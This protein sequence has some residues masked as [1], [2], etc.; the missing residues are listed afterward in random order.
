MFNM[1]VDF[2]F[3]N[4]GVMDAPRPELMHLNEQIAHHIEQYIIEHQLEPGSQLPSER[5]MVQIFGV[6]RPT[7]GK[8]LSTLEQRG[9]VRKV[10]G[11]GSFVID[12]PHSIITDTIQRFFQFGDC[13][14][15]QLITLREILEPEIAALAAIHISPELGDKLAELA[16]RH[17]ATYF[18]RDVASNQVHV[19][20]D[21]AFHH[22]LALATSNALIIAI[23]SGIH[24]ILEIWLKAQ[25]EVWL[26]MKT[27][28]RLDQAGQTAHQKICEAVLGH[29][30]VAA[31]RCMREHLKVARITLMR[32]LKQRRKA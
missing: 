23:S 14:H 27:N 3:A 30:P 6:S 24:Q 29:D 12:M 1:A 9:M 8:A 7:V 25:R 22:T 20:S 32:E 4:A 2:E 19:E 11:R 10:V 18:L 13:S 21:T 5:D 16:E 17:K 26:S 31:R 28:K 15:E